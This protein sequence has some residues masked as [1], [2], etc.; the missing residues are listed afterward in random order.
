M[1]KHANEKV[2]SLLAKA[3]AQFA[4]C[5]A[6]L[7][8]SEANHFATILKLCFLLALVKVNFEALEE[9]LRPQAT[10]QQYVPEFTK[11]L[12]LAIKGFTFRSARMAD[13]YIKFGEDYKSLPEETREK[14][15]RGCL[16]YRDG[17]RR[18][19][20]LKGETA[21][22]KAAKPATP[23]E[24]QVKRL[25]SSVLRAVKQA[26]RDD[27]RVKLEQARVL[28]ESVMGVSISTPAQSEPTI[29]A[30][31]P[32]KPMW[33]SLQLPDSWTALL[34]KAYAEGGDKA[35]NKTLTALISGVASSECTESPPGLSF[36]KATDLAAQVCNIE[37]ELAFGRRV[38][39]AFNERCRMRAE[40]C[41]SSV[42][43]VSSGA[44][45]KKGPKPKV[46]DPD[47]QMALPLS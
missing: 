36:T 21:P 17:E 32:S 28:I 7:G 14:E 3:E 1:K 11:R 24:A 5:L 18:M 26:P 30:S 44:A 6:K 23:F 37:A 31:Q 10:W 13:K 20:K 2:L 27:V 46:T 8:E 33:E 22:K 34:D 42:A 4:E 15:F 39:V 19:K 35:F 41:A 43:K 25:A 38:R 45:V 12:Q 29:E 47:A 40:S 9:A 16:T